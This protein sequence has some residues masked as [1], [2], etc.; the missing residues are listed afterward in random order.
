MFKVKNKKQQVDFIVVVLLFFVVIL[1]VFHI[2][3]W[4]LYR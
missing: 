3:F 1:N 4:Y 2:Y